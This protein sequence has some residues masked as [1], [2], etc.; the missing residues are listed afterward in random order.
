MSKFTD[1]QYLTQDQ[2][3]DSSNLEVRLEIHRRFSTNSYGWFNWV[4]DTLTQLP[5]DAN[6]LEL[7]TGSGALWVNIA[8]KIPTN[9]KVTL[10][11]LS[12]G[13]L[14]AASHNLVVTGRYF[15][16]KQI[17]VQSIP[18]KDEVFDIVIANHMLYH[19]PDRPS[20][21]AEIKRVLKKGG[22]L[23][24]TTVG[25]SHMKE[26]TDWLRRVDSDQDFS[27]FILPFT[28]ENGAEQLENFFSEVT[29][30]RY[31]DRLHITEI[32][33]FISYLRSAIRASEVSEDELAKVKLDLE[34][35][36]K[37][38]GR[39]FISKDSGLFKALK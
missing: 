33:P 36:L 1:Q 38:N 32:E 13:M 7:G 27:P 5:A 19:V 37:E 8:D 4:F 17:D 18:Y 29:I 14:D 11:D 31:E 24:A 3:K 34:K 21:L 12:Q 6:V 23:I 9:W 2:Y 35:D 25:Q 22:Y 26:I 10:S 15:K 28:L 39:I 30:S 16:F 20:A